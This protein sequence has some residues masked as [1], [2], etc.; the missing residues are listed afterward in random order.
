MGGGAAVAASSR[1]RELRRRPARLQRPPMATHRSRISEAAFRV[2][3]RL[4]RSKLRADQDQQRSTPPWSTATDGVIEAAELVVLEDDKSVQ[5]VVC[6]DPDHPRSRAAGKPE[7]PGNPRSHLPEPDGRRTAQAQ[8]QDP[9][10]WRAAKSVAEAY[11]L[12]EKGALKTIQFVK[13]TLFK[14]DA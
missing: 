1:I 4:R 13:S 9:G 6:T 14:T 11:F 7:D 8:R 10:R 12:K 2:A 3:I 5:Q